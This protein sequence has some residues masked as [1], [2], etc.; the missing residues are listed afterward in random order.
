MRCA[1]RHRKSRRLDGLLAQQAALEQE[2]EQLGAEQREADSI[3]RIAEQELIRAQAELAHN[4]KF[5]AGKKLSGESIGGE[6]T[7]IEEQMKEA[8]EQIAELINRTTKDEL[9]I[10]ADQNA[11]AQAENTLTALEQERAALAAA[12]NEKNIA[13]DGGA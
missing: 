10:E 8:N 9:S 2:I 1:P 4:G 12:V 6:L 11:A 7:Q 5:G 13:P 3:V